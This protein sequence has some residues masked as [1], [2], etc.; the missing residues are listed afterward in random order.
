MLAVILIV[1]ALLEN[2]A[3]PT[4]LKEKILKEHSDDSLHKV[5][6]TP[7]LLSCFG[8]NNYFA[9][10]FHSTWK[11]YQLL[12]LCWEL[13]QLCTTSL[14]TMLQ[15]QS[16]KHLSAVY[17]HLILLCSYRCRNLLQVCLSCCSS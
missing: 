12:T 14:P 7:K 2:S 17:L 6:L 13:F 9:V 15:G 1:Q 10:S 3:L 5:T 4:Q 8:V 11:H 16:G